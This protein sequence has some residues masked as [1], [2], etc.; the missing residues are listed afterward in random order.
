MR[1]VFRYA[2]VG[3]LGFTSLASVNSKRP[4]RRLE[5]APLN[6]T[7]ACLGNIKAVFVLLSFA[8]KYEPPSPSCPCGAGRTAPSGIPS[9]IGASNSM[10]QSKFALVC[11]NPKRICVPEKPYKFWPVCRREK[12][13]RLVAFADVS[14]KRDAADFDR[15]RILCEC[16]NHRTQQTTTRIR[17]AFSLSYTLPRFLRP[18]RRHAARLHGCSGTCYELRNSRVGLQGAA[19]VRMH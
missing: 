3:S 12:I 19:I 13:P 14:G 17:R 5:C 10:F 16:G 11:E 18:N 1:S 4:T 8:A 2:S 6:R 15:L 7:N 9:R